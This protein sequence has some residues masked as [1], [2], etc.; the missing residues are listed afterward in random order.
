MTSKNVLWKYSEMPFLP[1]QS[2]LS[3]RS[4][5]HTHTH[6]AQYVSSSSHLIF[7]ILCHFKLCTENGADSNK[8]HCLAI[9]MLALCMEP[10][11]AK[12]SLALGPPNPVPR[13]PNPRSHTRERRKDEEHRTVN[14]VYPRRWKQILSALQS[15]NYFYTTNATI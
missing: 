1:G 11:P 9:R 15:L 7:S 13:P 6:R 5:T 4:H 8:W 2:G 10:L 12:Y 14:R 3:P